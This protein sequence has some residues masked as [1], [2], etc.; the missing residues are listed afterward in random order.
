MEASA[1]D[2][3]KTKLVTPADYAKFVE[4]LAAQES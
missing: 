2:S 3:E 4:Q 1:F